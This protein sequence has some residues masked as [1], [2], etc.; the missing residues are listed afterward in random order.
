MA[1]ITAMVYCDAAVLSRGYWTLVNA[2]DA[3]DFPEF[4]ATHPGWDVMLGVSDLVAETMDIEVEIVDP[5]LEVE[6]EPGA[7]IY[8]DTD[9]LERSHRQ[10]RAWQR[11]HTGRVEIVRPCVM[12]VRVS[13]AGKFAE[14]GTIRVREV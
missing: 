3:L 14:L 8:Y 11:F 5:E 7:L 10:R 13:L 12:D 1:N 6:D 4:P 2:F 9:V